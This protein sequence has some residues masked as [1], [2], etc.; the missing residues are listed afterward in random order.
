MISIIIPVFHEEDRIEALL[1][2]FH[3]QRTVVDY[4][5]IIVDGD[6]Q[7]STIKSIKQREGLIII[8]SKKGRGIQMNAGA[9]SAKGEILLF[10]HADTLL[11]Y[12]ALEKVIFVMQKS[13]YVGGAFDLGVDSPNLLIKFIALCASL[14]SRITRVPFGD[15]AIFV[16]RD[17]FNTIGGYKEIPLME[18]VD[19]MKRIRK[20]GYK[21]CIIKDRVKTSS[22]NWEKNG[23]LFTVLRNWTIQILY[24]LKISPHILVKFYYR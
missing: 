3:N 18:D 5:I 23:I 24:S 15:Q 8:D 21:I 7:R 2:Y 19:L 12:G 14:R 13:T 1:S 4:E 22:R 6:P 16:R 11:P 9:R 17:Y 10:L 20:K